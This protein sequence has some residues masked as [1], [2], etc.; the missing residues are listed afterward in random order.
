MTIH[1]YALSHTR[2][3]TGIPKAKW[4][5]PSR[6]PSASAEPHLL[7]VSLSRG[8]IPN[9]EGVQVHRDL[10]VVGVPPALTDEQGFVQQEGVPASLGVRCQGLAPPN[11]PVHPDR[12]HRDP[13]WQRLGSTY[14]SMQAPSTFLSR[15]QNLTHPPFFPNP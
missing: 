4:T 2:A 1:F 13:S 14:T 9:L 3:H 10:E 15:S 6:V 7:V 12:T 5:A 8:V 11:L